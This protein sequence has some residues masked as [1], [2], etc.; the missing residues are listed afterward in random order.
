MKVVNRGLFFHGNG[1]IGF[2]AVNL[3]S[4]IFEPDISY[5]CCIPLS[6]YNTPGSLSVIQPINI[7]EKNSSIVPKYEDL[8]KKGTIIMTVSL[9][10]VRDPLLLKG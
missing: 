4:V 6:H 8:Q 1:T 5:S 7:Y 10:N 9:S 2:G 3:K